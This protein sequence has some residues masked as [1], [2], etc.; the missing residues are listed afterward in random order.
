MAELKNLMIYEPQTSD[1][2]KPSSHQILDLQDFPECQLLLFKLL[3]QEVEF[4]E[5]T[6]HRPCPQR[7][8]IKTL[9]TISL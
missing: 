5:L 2:P 9:V 1:L 8:Q 3:R 6:N 4:G 7:Y